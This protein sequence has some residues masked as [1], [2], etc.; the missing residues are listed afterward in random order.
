MSLTLAGW[1]LLDDLIEEYL[2]FFTKQQPVH[3]GLSLRNKWVLPAY[4]V[5]SSFNQV[6]LHVWSSFLLS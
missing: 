2:G 5:M 3:L 6:Q 1:F 4:S